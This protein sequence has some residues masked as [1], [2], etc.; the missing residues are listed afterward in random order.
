MK[1]YAL[2][3]GNNEYKFLDPLK[4]AV[5]DAESVADK[6]K[7]LGFDVDCKCNLEREKLDYYIASLQD[8]I[9]KYDATILYYAGH[10]FQVNNQNLLIP[11]DY[12][13][14]DDPRTA[15]R[16]G[17]P[18]NAILD[19][20]EGDVK[21][22][23]II[24]LDACRVIRGFRGD[25]YGFVQMYAPQGT[26]VAF[27]TSPGQGSKE[28]DRYKHGIYT[29]C[30]LEHM[31]DVRITIEEMFKRVRTALANETNG[32]QISWEHT[33]LIGDFMLKRNAIYDGMNYSDDALS[34]G[35]YI[36]ERGSSVAPI[37]RDLKSH[38]WNIQAS[39][40]DQIIK[41]DFSTV[42]FDDLFVLGRNI[43]Q[44]ACGN[45]FACIRF[46]ENFKSN[47]SIPFEAKQHILNG[48]VYEIYY[49]HDGRLRYKLKYNY[50]SDV[51]STLELDSYL[52]CREFIES[53]LCDESR[54]LFYIPGQDNKVDIRVIVEELGD[55]ALITD[56]I[57][58]GRSIYYSYY[59]HRK[60]NVDGIKES[61]D[62]QRK[63]TK[64]TFE[65][66]LRKKMCVPSGYLKVEY[67]GCD[68]SQKRLIVPSYEYDVWSYDNDTDK[69]ES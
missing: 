52:E 18:I 47:N 35:N 26:L 15:D 38:T 28:S 48:M 42:N 67:D 64:I 32:A 40:L 57:H 68:I 17:Y 20:L 62:S 49:D 43:Y 54:K 16:R 3:I 21:K 53:R 12:N 4:Y 51:L 6:L 50:A 1:R 55:A 36:F 37:V 11:I 29:K 5:S 25:G 14:N 69:G 19:K 10:G 2:C 23:R 8:K 56:I 13:D 22:T 27:S 44:A 33:S 45:C 60:V 7:L 30:L 66:E 63:I 31:D 41:I 39:A 34:D 9:E 24:I 65:S 46:I 61:E 59:F 58:D